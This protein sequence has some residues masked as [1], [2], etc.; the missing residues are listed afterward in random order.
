MFNNFVCFSGECGGHEELDSSVY[1]ET[2][3]K[4]GDAHV[5]E[6]VA[7]NKTFTI[8]TLRTTIKQEQKLVYAIW[9]YQTFEYFYHCVFTTRKTFKH[10]C[11]CF[12]F[13]TMLQC[14]KLGLKWGMEFHLKM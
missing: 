13:F 11:Y 10:A 8:K 4:T 6:D 7:G 14:V 5:Y 3:S 12:P 9:D 2:R 1:S